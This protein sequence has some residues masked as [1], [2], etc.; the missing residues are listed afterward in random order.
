MRYQPVPDY[1]M[2]TPRCRHAIGNMAAY[3]EAAIGLGLREIGF[4]DHAPLPEE[5]D[6]GWRMKAG[7]LD[8]Y[9]REAEEV[10]ARFRCR[11]QVRIA[12]EVDYYPGCESF[13]GDLA[14]AYAWDYIIGSVHYIG[15]WGFD[16]EDFIDHWEGKDIEQAY[17][18]YFALVGDSARSG[19]FDI[20]AH[21][22]LIKKFGHRPPLGSRKVFEAEETM[23]RQ[24]K[25]SGCV[26]EIS[27]AGLRKPVG[28][29]YPHARI[30]AKATEMGIPFA[31]GSDA[32]APGEVGHAMQTCLAMLDACG[33]RH[34]ACFDQRRMKLQPISTQQ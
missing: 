7:E 25:E 26:L 31:Y 19:L 29:I 20:I 16:N 6:D 32:H 2:H 9:I 14:S 5:K 17:C 23:L 15:A 24:V 10:R 8:D 21:P 4:S 18:E 33:C 30:I 13:V 12:L 3:A 27:S 11:L 34:V 28:E 22:D 1:H